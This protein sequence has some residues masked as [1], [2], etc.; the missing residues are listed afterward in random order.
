MDEFPIDEELFEDDEEGGLLTTS[1]S[2]V[3]ETSTA[4]V[5]LASSSR[6][7]REKEPVAN[8]T[9]T[10]ANATVPLPPNKVALSSLTVS[11][12]IHVLHVL[13]CRNIEEIFASHNIS[14]EDLFYVDNLQDLEDLKTEL[15]TIQ[16]KKVLLKLLEWKTKG[17]PKAIF[18]EEVDLEASRKAMKALKEA[19]DGLRPVLR[20]VQHVVVGG[21]PART[22][23][24]ASRSYGSSRA[25]TTASTT[26]ED[27]VTSSR[28]TGQK[29]SRSPSSA[30]TVAASKSTAVAKASGNAAVQRVAASPSSSSA[31][32]PVMQTETIISSLQNMIK[33]NNVQQHQSFLSHLLETQYNNKQLSVA[34]GH[35]NV[36]HTMFVTIDYFD[37]QSSI[38]L[39]SS[40]FDVMALLLCCTDDLTQ[41]TPN[42]LR[43]FV[44]EQ[45]FDR[46]YAMFLKY[47]THADVVRSSWK[48]L[49]LMGIYKQCEA[50]LRK[51]NCWVELVRMIFQYHRNVFV[52]EELIH[53]AAN[54]CIRKE[55]RDII[56]QQRGALAGTASSS[57]SS[58]SRST[59]NAAQE[60]DIC[61]FIVSNLLP[62]YQ[63]QL[64][65]SYKLSIAINKLITEEAMIKHFRSNSSC[66]LLLQCIK[67]HQTRVEVLQSFAWI[68]TNLT[69][70]DQCS[71]CLLE[72][73]QP[74]DMLNFLISILLQYLDNISSTG[75]VSDNGS[76]TSVGELLMIILRSLV[77]LSCTEEVTEK[78]TKT[79]VCDA[80]VNVLQK[81]LTASQELHVLE[82]CCH[83][84]V[85]IA[86]HNVH[87]QRLGALSGCEFLVRILQRYSQP[88][89]LISYTIRAITNLTNSAENQAKIGQCGGCGAMLTILQSMPKDAILVER[90]CRS[91]A[92]LSQHE[93][94][95][96][97][98]RKEKTVTTLLKVIQRHSNN[99]GIIEEACC[100]LA[101]LCTTATTMNELTEQRTAPE[102]SKLLLKLLKYY[103]KNPDVSLQLLRV[104]VNICDEVTLLEC[105]VAQG[106]LDLT[107]ELLPLHKEETPVIECVTQLVVIVSSINFDIA[108]N[109]M[110][111]SSLLLALIKPE[112]SVL[113]KMTVIEDVCKIM[114]NLAW[115]EELRLE[116]TDDELLWQSLIAVVLNVVEY[117]DED[118]GTV[119]IILD[120]VSEVVE[121]LGTPVSF[122]LS[123]ILSSLEDL[124]NNSNPTLALKELFHK[125]ITAISFY[126][127]ADHDDSS[128]VTKLLNLFTRL[129]DWSGRSNGDAMD[130]LRPVFAKYE[131]GM[132]VWHKVLKYYL[133]DIGT[134]SSLLPCLHSALLFQQSNADYVAQIQGYAVLLVQVLNI[135]HQHLR[136]YAIPFID[137]LGIL[138]KNPANLRQFRRTGLKD[139][140]SKY[141]SREE[142]IE[143]NLV[144]HVEELLCIL[145]SESTEHDEE[146]DDIA[147]G[148]GDEEDGEVATKSR[149]GRKKS[150]T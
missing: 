127:E 73:S 39:L 36:I 144:K 84:I 58:S 63:T 80:I 88:V 24:K 7:R 83:L 93:V 17:V 9:T 67:L 123:T 48:I 74:Q 149:R 139:F 28:I 3:V 43:E 57:S 86:H 141:Q 85:N 20:T 30:T 140:L 6:S 125:I 18:D 77:N 70:D 94:N 128:T 97:F 26:D 109:L 37:Q 40:L 66:Q 87:R 121:N 108:Y 76:Q 102:T 60:M 145:D 91:I 10:P 27:A 32:K 90:L 130:D 45:G 112:N 19:A 122:K 14:G 100:G 148:E 146:P 23:N 104:I 13:G 29:R 56:L 47:Q 50:Q 61:E 69:Y 119:A 135:H 89:T 118:A 134:V 110:Q 101:L 120:K 106:L 99:S 150:R 126:S 113:Q 4:A 107:M 62:S 33:S 142:I 95:Q 12:S 129:V 111:R 54:G 1:S 51:N 41:Y 42:T 5:T 53:A 75:M 71:K 136:R 22:A 115:H 133:T 68:V 147:R 49:K 132:K 78:L 96:L 2:N 137:S 79:K 82:E 16:L 15:P 131:E 8:S 98:F 117:L 103:R 44:H 72:L 124:E 21:Q 138:L 116:M 105:L 52:L 35:A 59:S 34:L 55:N 143:S 11:Q 81:Y 65:L 46:V 31:K 25:T 38:G 92:N 114:L 64:I